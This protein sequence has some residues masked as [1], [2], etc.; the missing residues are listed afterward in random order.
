MDEQGRT[1][2]TLL[3]TSVEDQLKEMLTVIKDSTD[4]T[5][6]D[7]MQKLREVVN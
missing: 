2:R 4:K 3:C 7:D 6:I 1:C 5:A